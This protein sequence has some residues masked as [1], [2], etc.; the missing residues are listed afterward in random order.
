MAQPRL[1]VL[2][3]LA[4]LALHAQL[5]AGQDPST[6]LRT[7]YPIKPIRIVTS[8]AGGGTDFVARAIALGTT[9]SFGQPLVVDNRGGIIP[10]E[11]VA[12]APP[13]GYTLLVIGQA[14]WIAPLLQDV[15]YDPLKDFSFIT[16]TDRSPAVLVV[17]PSVPVKSVKELIA[18]AKANPGK[19]NYGSIQAGS[20]A[21]LAA[22]LFKS[23]AGVNI[24]WVPYKSIGAAV[25]DLLAAQLQML[26]STPAAVMPH[27]TAGKLRALAV[28]TAHPTPLT[29][30]LPTIA[31]SGLPG[32]EAVSITGV[33]APAKTPSAIINRLN[34]EIV[35]LVNAPELKAQLFNSG[36][37]VVGSTP[38]EL[39][40]AVKSDM[41]KFGKVIKEIGIKI[42]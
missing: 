22:E 18:Y 30:G 29:P 15:P 4:L 25:T 7:G 24:V 42:N 6:E 35:R 11:I 23:M 9:G 8:G 3:G 37:E 34:R 5:A 31:E 17:H 2:I 32:Y 27:I 19:L 13:D 41:T 16:I 39:A 38:D 28:A 1:F 21:H 36:S 40:A 10:G 26:M 20:A 12:K 33:F 14:H